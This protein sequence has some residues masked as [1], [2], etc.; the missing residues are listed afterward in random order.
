[1]TDAPGFT[2]L[3]VRFPSPKLCAVTLDRPDAGNGIDPVMV[4][5]LDRALS[6]AEAT[7]TCRV[8]V[9]QGRPGLFCT[10]MDL[11]AASDGQWTPEAFRPQVEGFMRLLLRLSRASLVTVAKIEGRVAGGGM[12][13]ACACDLVVATPDT[14][15]SLPEATWGLIP[16]CVL[17]FLMRRSGFQPAYRMALTTATVTA[18]E[19]RDWRLVDEIGEPIDETVRR[20]VLRAA[21][22]DRRT[23]ADLK[24]YGNDLS[25]ITDSAAAHAVDEL[26]RVM[27][28][29]HVREAIA[30]HVARTAAAGERRG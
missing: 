25:P 13:L 26:C 21:H 9:L 29:P 14:V 1:M 27:S 23:V 22:V 6:L 20:I 24:R 12:G 4:G 16:A 7:D 11:A 18:Q 10:G 3:R 2:S 15:F 19:A 30:G 17:P 8:L 28:Q 5:E